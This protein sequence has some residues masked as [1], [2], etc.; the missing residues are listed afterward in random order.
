MIV[1]LPREDAELVIVTTMPGISPDPGDDPFCAC[2]EIGRA[3]FVV[4]LN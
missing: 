4:T 1:N 2:A 3:D